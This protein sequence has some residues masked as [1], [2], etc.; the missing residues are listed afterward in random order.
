MSN[1]ITE[2]DLEGACLRLNQITGSPVA[3]Y[4]NNPETG[5][6][7]PQAGCYHL[8][9]AYG[10]VCLHRMSMTP[11]CSGV[12]S[13]LRTGHIPKRELFGLIH[14]FINGVSL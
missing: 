1:R 4:L 3:P 9:H 11:G 13:P 5:K 6:Y 7:E 8:S 14:A 12:D 2:K 10:G